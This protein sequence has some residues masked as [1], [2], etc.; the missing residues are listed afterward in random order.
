MSKKAIIIGAGFS[1]ATCARKLAENDYEV[2]V[3]DKFS[4]IGGNAY[5]YLDK[6]I[7]VHQYGPHIFHSNVEEAYKFLSRFT[8]WFPY[9]HRV[10]ASLKD[11]FIPVPFNLE[12]LKRCFGDEKAKRIEENLIK[13]YGENKKVGILE[14]RQNPNKEIQELADFVV[15]N[16]FVYYSEKQW[17]TTM[18][19]LDPNTI[20]R[21]PVYTSYEDRYFTDTYQFQPLEGYTKLFGNMLNHKNIKLLLNTQAKDV[22]SIRDNKVYYQD[23]LF[24]G[25]TIFTGPIDEFF[26]NK[27]GKLPY[28]SLRFELEYYDVDSYQPAAVVNYTVDQDYTRISEFK[29]FTTSNPPKNGTYIIKEYSLKYKQDGKMIPYY[30]II[31]NDNMEVFNKYKE[32]CEKIDNFYLCGR[33]GNY[34][35]INM[36]IAVKNALELSNQIIAKEEK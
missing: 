29:K 1:G 12:S 18:D 28:R 8:K 6:G 30:P 16:V 13:E 27:F 21:V 2:I 10:I 11:K 14:L 36:D 32:Y 3:I 34:K 35:Y 15:K 17:G 31:N 23:K 7:L 19:K 9:E 20:A 5:D 33:L 26:D 22:I 25:I 4:H 24:D